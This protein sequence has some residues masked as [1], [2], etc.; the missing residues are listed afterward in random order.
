MRKKTIY[1]LTDLPIRSSLTARIFMRARKNFL[2]QNLGER[3]VK[4]Y[5]FRHYS[6]E[7]AVQVRFAEMLG[8]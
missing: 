4:T 6:L 5:T 8:Y 2:K 7:T 1:S 3:Y